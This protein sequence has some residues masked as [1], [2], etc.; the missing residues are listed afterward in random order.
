MIS[1]LVGQVGHVHGIDM[2]AEQLDVAKG[3][4]EDQ[5]KTFFGT[6]DKPNVTFHQGFIEDLSF[7]ET[8]S[9]DVVVSNCV[10]NLSPKKE[11]VMQEIYRILKPGGEFYFSDVFVDRRLKTEI[12]FDPLL[13][14]EC[15]GGALYTR[16]FINM[17]KNVG[18]KDPRKLTSAPITIRND[19]I[20]KMVGNTKFDS[21]TFRLFKLDSL[22]RYL[23][24]IN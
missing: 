3:A 15:L 23:Y 11:L 22:V 20:E 4:L 24:Y 9:V 1:Q 7:L 10:V 2:T 17:A 12:A 21:I 16:D 6:A 5:M 14:S 13:H 18:F 19:D 8:S